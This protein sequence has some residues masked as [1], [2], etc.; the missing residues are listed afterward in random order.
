[1][2]QS[3]STGGPRYHR[4]VMASEVVEVFRPLSSGVVVDTTLGGGGHTRKLSDELEKGI[5]MIA[6]DRDPDAL[7]NA[8]DMAKGGARVREVTVLRGN[9][10]DMRHLLEEAGAPHPVGF[11]FDLGVSSHQLEVAGRGFS[12]RHDGPLDMRMGPDAT[13]TADDIVNGWDRSALESI[14][15]RLGEDRMAARIASAIV[16]AR[17]ITST[18]HLAAVVAD[19]MP[20]ALRRR[21][22][23][24]RRTFQA[25]RMAVNDELEVLET[26]LDTA[27][28][29]LAPG[30]RCAVISYHSLEDRL[31]KRR[32]NEG[33]RGCTCPPDLPICA[34]GAEA[35]LRLLTRGP[36]QASAV[37]VAGNPRARSAK[38]RAVEKMGVVAS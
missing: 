19:A 10:G 14:I 15:R 37:E 25:V 34:C 9:F 12:Y 6:I 11:L 31:V 21:G 29:M 13:V 5:R 27:L 36:R 3:R 28:E 30:G 17:P 26:G 4:P 33:A 24:A 22:H 38:L 8:G 20:A 23:P 16:A 7:H 18:G 35:D 2:T 1:M 32:F